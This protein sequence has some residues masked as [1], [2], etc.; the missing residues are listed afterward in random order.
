MN[1]AS[2][3][4]RPLAF[5]WHIMTGMK[6]YVFFSFVAVAFAEIGW[7]ITPLISKVL[8]DS[9]TIGDPSNAATLWTVIWAAIG[10]TVANG[11]GLLS[12]RTS[13]YLC[14]HWMNA[15]EKRIYQVLFS[16]LSKHD[17][18]FFA[19]TFAGSLVTKC[20][21]IGRGAWALWEIAMW[22]FLPLTVGVIISLFLSFMVSPFIGLFVVAWMIVQTFI[23]LQMGK[24]KRDL[25]KAAAAE[26]SKRTGQVVDSITNIKTVTLFAN[27]PHEEKRLNKTLDSF[28][29]AAKTN[30]RYSEMMLLTNNI[31][32]LLLRSAM[33]GGVVYLWATSQASTGDILMMYSV[34][35]QIGRQFFDVG[36][37]IN[38]VFQSFGELDEG[39]QTIATG[40][41]IIDVP[42]AKALKVPK[43]AIEFNDINFSYKEKKQQTKVFKDFN[44]V[45]KP[46]EKV[47]LVGLSGAGKT[48]L[49]KLFLRLY[50]AQS[51]SITIDGQP[52][53]KIGLDS[54]RNS[55]AVIPQEPALFHRSLKEN[56]TYGK[57]KASQ[58]EVEKAAKLAQAHDF[59]KKLSQG[60]ATLVGERGVKLSGGQCQRVAIARAIL[61][62]APILV[63]DEATSAL[64][65]ENEI[66]IQTALHNLIQGKTVIAIAHR[67]STLRE[68]DRIIVLEDGNIIQDG[69]HSSLMKK[70]GLYQKLWKQQSEGFLQE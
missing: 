63:L 68:M 29:T 33:L 27:V 20:A 49:V 35:V 55:V 10:L 32:V 16:Y 51:G 19:D 24:R 13:G 1:L 28:M 45:I 30:W 18:G 8:V 2:F 50:E 22:T 46:G 40:H 54:L 64:D 57:L 48:T 6:H 60:Y 23:S 9:L 37:R 21:N 25:S 5:C 44:L 7:G 67:L 3:R 47:G 58:K 26:R 65:S 11:I 4:T 41:Q 34:S 66:A 15:M 59:I 52:I 62:D 42:G 12:Y 38:Q 39:L 31:M 14:S 61:K 36:R 17:L 69:N 53:D 70:K 43:G 56:I